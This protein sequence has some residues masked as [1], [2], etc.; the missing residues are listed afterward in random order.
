MLS[1]LFMRHKTPAPRFAPGLF[2]GL[3]VVFAVLS[4]TKPAIGLAGLGTLAIMTAG[5]VELNREQ[6][7]DQYNKAYKKR[8]GWHSRWTEPKPTYYTLNVVVL[9]PVVATLGVLCLWAAYTIG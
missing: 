1:K 4:Q 2:F 3:I 9:W 5:L 7:W 6:I 8:K